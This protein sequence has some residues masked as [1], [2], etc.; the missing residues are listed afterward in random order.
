MSFRFALERALEPGQR[1][2]V[3]HKSK[4]SS[5]R[6]R[7]LYYVSENEGEIK[8][9]NAVSDE[10][11]EPVGEDLGGLCLKTVERVNILG[12]NTVIFNKDGRSY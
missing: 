10:N 8:L 4:K 7:A 12:T 5:L 2:E 6:I 9:T 11:G 1:I 3:C